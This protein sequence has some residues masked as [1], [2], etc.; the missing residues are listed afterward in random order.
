MNLTSDE[1][2]SLK[3]MFVEKKKDEDIE[4]EAIINSK[5][6][7]DKKNF[8]RI[9]SY[10]KN[11]FKLEEHLETLDISL[12][13]KNL[14]STVSSIR[15]SLNGLDT[16]QKYCKTNILVKLKPSYLSKEKVK[17]PLDI[18]RYDIRFNLKKETVPDDLEKFNNIIDTSPK[19]FRLKKR[20]SFYNENF[21]YDLS[22]IKSSDSKKNNMK[23][24]L[25]S[26]LMSSSPKYEIE[27]EYLGNTGKKKDNDSNSDDYDEDS[28][29]DD[30][31][32]TE[33]IKEFINNISRILQI[34]N[35]SEFILDKE[36]NKEVESNYKKLING[37][38]WV[39]PQPIT[40]EI[41]N[42]KEL[43]K[44]DEK[45][46][47]IYS[48]TAKADGMRTM[49]F[50]DDSYRLFYVTRKKNNL[51]FT[52]TG[53]KLKNEISNNI[54]FDGELTNIINKKGELD[55]NHFL[56]LIFDL[57]FIDSEDVRGEVLYEKDSE[58][59]RY[60]RIKNLTEG[61]K[62]ELEIEK[63]NNQDIST[64]LEVNLKNFQFCSEQKENK[65]GK[66]NKKIFACIKNILLEKKNYETDG[67]IFT[68]ENFA[69]GSKHPG[70]L[71]TP[72]KNTGKTWE[73][74]FKWKPPELNSIDFS[75]FYNSLET[76]DGNL[77]RIL[78]L[79]VGMSNSDYLD[80][81][82]C[83]SLFEDNKKM[84]NSD[85]NKYHLVD[86]NPVGIENI[87]KAKVIMDDGKIFAE[88]GKE[89]Q[90]KSV[91]EFSFDIDNNLWIP[92]RVRDDKMFGNN[93]KTAYSV[94]NSIQNPISEEM[95]KKGKITIDKKEEIQYYGEKDYLHLKNM[96]NFHNWIVKKNLISCVADGSKSLLDLAVG[97]GG[98]L[99]KWIDCKLKLV[100]GIDIGKEGLE[101]PI[102][103]A[104]KRYHKLLAQ[105]KK[106]PDAYF[107][108]G[109]CSKNLS[110]GDAGKDELNSEYLR[111]LWG[112]D[113]I[114][115]E[116]KLY[117]LVKDKFDV[118]S[119]QFAIHYFLESKDKFVQ[120]V[121]NISDN[122]KN[123]GYFV[124]T[125][126]DGDKIHSLLKD[127]EK[128]DFVSGKDEDG[129]EVWKIVKKYDNSLWDD[130]NNNEKYSVPIEVY[131]KTINPNIEYLVDSS[132]LIETMKTFG[133]EL[134]KPKKTSV[135]KSKEGSFEK[136]SGLINKENELKDYEKDYSFLNKWFIFKKKEVSDIISLKKK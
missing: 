45:E 128:D 92:I 27:I 93:Y 63:I 112:T 110:N 122:L 30:S 62:H 2:K 121:K 18:N 70:V 133:L 71:D 48:V 103:G 37:E 42:L 41:D 125:T 11:N 90:N 32:S 26:G 85:K 14:D 66:E 13:D 7:L 59:C 78:S 87:N 46:S 116:K 23:S 83:K 129:N 10:L 130:S 55:K 31:E 57:Y 29:D 56:Y 49:L 40:L 53:Y 119:C 44:N 101:N 86:F 94:W 132:T 115:K 16:I 25:K 50:I 99:Q 97:R 35:N 38:N 8:E 33:L 3:N 111:L 21:R 98:D 76:I 69:V 109:D 22:I 100:V 4:L 75:V 123:G 58:I 107:I 118:I 73:H 6:I 24:L 61:E 12:N 124:C 126:I 1:F 127:K 36:T 136:L 72:I 51:E 89:I 134:S 65:K 95:L 68:P 77:Y 105:K 82:L 131:L 17:K 114:L 52:F 60:N 34:Q 64:K 15:A 96:R 113:N 28:D 9:L 108:W 106:I 79:K 91:V 39:G 135:I 81:N 43:V 20:Y 102:D 120:F 54:L 67:L 47:P 19:Y 5:R 117:G 84:T 80:M 88:D 104:C 74:V